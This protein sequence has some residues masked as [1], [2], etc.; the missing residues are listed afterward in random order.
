MTCKITRLLCTLQRIRNSSLF[1]LP[2][3]GRISLLAPLLVMAAACSPQEPTVTLGVYSGR[4]YNTDKQL[5]KQFTDQTGIGINLLEAKDKVLLQRL[6]AEGNNSPADVLVLADA[7]RLVKA[8]GM[9]LYQATN[10]SQLEADVPSN[11]RDPQGHWYALTRRARV[12]I[13]NPEIVDPATIKSY[14][15]L[16]NPALKGKLCLRNRKSPY[17][18]SLVADQIILRGEA[19]TAKWIRGMANNVSQEFFPKDTPQVQAVGKGKCGVAVVNTYYVGRMLAGRKGADNKALAEKVKVV[20]PNP[21]H[22]NVSGAGVTASS[23]NPKAALKL[24]EFLASPNAGKGYAAANLEYP[25]KG[26][27][28]NPI[29]RSWGTFKADGVSVEQLGAKNKQAQQLMKDNGWK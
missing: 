22:V 16:A 11:L 1:R 21:T 10:S 27:G 18:Q 28:D 5:Y 9:G 25:V 6:E 8:S 23:D 2:A 7:A 26:F 4:H 3:L 29:L 19:A 12:P 17:N 13:V 24:I 14:D 20:F 15:D